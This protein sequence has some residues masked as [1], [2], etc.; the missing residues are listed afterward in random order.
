MKIIQLVSNLSYG[1]AIGD[2]VLMLHSY[3]RKTCEARIM[4]LSVHPALENLADAMDFS[5]IQP[6]DVVILHKAS[7]DVLTKPF[8]KLRCKKLLIYH[9]ITPPSFFFPY[10]LIVAFNQ[11]RGR[12]QLKS[13]ASCV[14]WAWG[15]SQYN[16]N[17]LTAMGF[18]SRRVATLPLCL[19]NQ[20]KPPV[21]AELAAGLRAGLGA[22]ILSIGR[23]APNKKPEDIIKAFYL[24]Q[25]HVDPHAKLYLVGSWQGMEKYYAKIM[26]F[27]ADLGLSGVTMTGHV[28]NEDKWT[29]L[30]CADLMLHMSEHEGFCVPLLEAMLCDVPILA[31]A[32]SAVPETLGNPDQLFAEKD[33]P[34]VSERM[35]E[36]ITD[37]A[38][39][40]R[41]LNKQRQN[42]QRFLPGPF[43]TRL[44][45][46]LDAVIG[47]KGNVYDENKG[48]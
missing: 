12:K 47:A 36:M 2:E 22:N 10:N 24:Y 8:R 37:Q 44:S 42:L 1:D 29:Y 46:L 18:C 31:Y 34:A 7:G 27:I 17:E 48:I 16:C 28:S 9:N 35:R 33:F 39:R 40:S 11:R 30:Q 5:A 45:Q 26:G 21:N 32:N 23:I 13:L 41:I 4:T 25:K 14:D 38:Y 3:L 6:E 43:Q 20:E 19:P 15:D